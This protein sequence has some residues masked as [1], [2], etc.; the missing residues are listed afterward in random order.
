VTDF[1]LGFCISGQ[2]RLARAA[3]A[4]ARQLG[5]T[6]ALVLADY[7][8][9]ADLEAFCD[10]HGAPL[11]RVAKGPRAG[12][13]EQVTRACMDARLDLLALTF[14]WLIQPALIAHYPGRIINVH[15]ALLPAFRG[16]N[17]LEA[18]VQSGT[19]YAGASIHE[20][21]EGMDTGAVIAQC[22]VGLRRD[23]TAEAV[24]ARMFNLLRPMFLQV[25]RWYVEGRVE[26]DAAGRVVVRGGTYGELPISPAL[27]MGFVD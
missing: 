5:V 19:R 23:D 9:A 27:E 16:M 10:A 21:D 17:A 12:F 20:V 7:R 14:E 13:D 4:N 6:P 25:I 22:V 3:I 24:G 18:A 15:P 2:G 26:R 11:V 1:R 8:A